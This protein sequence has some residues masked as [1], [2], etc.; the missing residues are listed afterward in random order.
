M[1]SVRKGDKVVGS[2]CLFS[3]SVGEM[4]AGGDY[5]AVRRIAEISEL[6]QASRYWLKN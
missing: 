4:I 3:L 5:S 2:F 6:V 1:V